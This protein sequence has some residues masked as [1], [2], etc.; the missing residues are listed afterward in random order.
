MSA[1]AWL[2][3]G[4]LVTLAVIG[5]PWSGGGA[6]RSGRPGA[7]HHLVRPPGAAEGER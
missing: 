3:W 6:S 2:T 4:F 5:M 1:L 7:R